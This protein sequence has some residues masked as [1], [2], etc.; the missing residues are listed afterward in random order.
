MTYSLL[1]R[2]PCCVE[3][4]VFGSVGGEKRISKTLPYFHTPHSLQDAPGFKGEMLLADAMHNPAQH[5]DRCVIAV[6]ASKEVGGRAYVECLSAREQARYAGI[7]H[8]DRK[9][10]WLAGRLVA[11]Y[12]FLMQMNRA[13]T[14]G[15]GPPVLVPITFERLAA[16]LPWMYRQVEVLPPD[17]TS[18]GAPRLTWGGEACP[19]HRVSLSHANGTTCACIAGGSALGI[20]LERS[21]PR[22]H[23]FYQGN[24]TEAER[25]WVAQTAS[26]TRFSPAWLYT[27]LWTLKESVLKSNVLEKEISVWDFPR[28]DVQLQVD[29][30]QLTAA[31]QQARLGDQFLLS[32]ARVS[33]PSCRADVRIAMTATRKLVL[34]VLNT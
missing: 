25:H 34:T 6:V 15:A 26:K 24:F 20:D 18:R 9:A 11:K 7:G 21:V 22:I 28:I 32:T 16:F 5:T 2:S 23:A 33:A 3:V 10:R 8:P 12:L 30:R 13:G 31:S 19:A 29:P 17:T 1:H 4:W 27:L 14:I